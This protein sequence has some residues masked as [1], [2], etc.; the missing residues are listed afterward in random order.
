LSKL[1]QSMVDDNNNQNG[2][3]EK[4]NEEIK[5][6]TAEMIAHTNN[7]DTFIPN[8]SIKTSDKGF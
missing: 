5:K 1:E 8:E 3:S 4:I 6:L 2:E 7:Y